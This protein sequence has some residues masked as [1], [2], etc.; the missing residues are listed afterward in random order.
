MLRRAW[1][2]IRFE[3][4]VSATRADVRLTMIGGAPLVGD[5]RCARCSRRVA[6]SYARVTVD[7]A[8]ELLARWI[9]RRVAGAA[10]CRARPRGGVVMV[11]VS[12]VEP[13]A[14]DGPLDAST[15]SRCRFSP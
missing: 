11:S 1:R 2:P 8:S 14:C 7:G 6:K 15:R 12:E 3:S 9:A 4:L 10:P 5:A 13:R